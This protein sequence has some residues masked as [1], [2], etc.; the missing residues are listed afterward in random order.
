MN[1]SSTELL[2]KSRPGD[3]A[4]AQLLSPMR[5]AQHHEARRDGESETGDSEGGSRRE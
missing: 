2:T 5:K 4:V 3:V 1:D